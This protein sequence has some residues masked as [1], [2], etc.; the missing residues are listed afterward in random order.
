MSQFERGTLSFK[1][2]D[3]VSKVGE[4]YDIM[5]EKEAYDR[6]VMFGGKALAISDIQTNYPKISDRTTQLTLSS[7][8]GSN[9]TYLQKMQSENA[10]QNNGIHH[11]FKTK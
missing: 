7:S 4:L 5:D 10:N 11:V 9:Q 2:V 3:G 8:I 1:T 6:G